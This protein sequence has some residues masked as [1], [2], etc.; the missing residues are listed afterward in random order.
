[1]ICADKRVVR[2]PGGV[3]ILNRAL[4]RERALKPPV[5]TKQVLE[6]NKMLKGH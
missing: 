2:M 4:V 3:E 5:L 1:M 6:K